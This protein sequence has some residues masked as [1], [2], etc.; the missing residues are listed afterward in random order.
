MGETIWRT[1]GPGIEI[2]GLAFSELNEAAGV[3]WVTEVGE[4]PPDSDASEKHF[5]C[6]VRGMME[7]VENKRRRFRGSVDCVGS[8]H[9]P[10]PLVVATSKQYR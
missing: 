10:P 7:S 2:G 6:G 1:V 3:L 5:T 4:P 9:T 8:W